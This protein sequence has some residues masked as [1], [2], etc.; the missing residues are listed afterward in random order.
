MSRRQW[1][2]SRLAISLITALALLAVMVTVSVA[3]IPGSYSYVNACYGAKTGV[4][5]VIDY[6]K[7]HCASGEKFLRWNQK[8]SPGARGLPGAQG[9][10]GP[11]S[12]LVGPTGPTGARGATGTTGASGA[13]GATGSPGPT[14]SQGIPGASGA[15]GA[16]GAPGPAGPSTLTAL[17][18]SP[19]SA[20]NSSG[21]V[22]ITT[23][24]S[25]D[26][27]VPITLSCTKTPTVTV[28]V[29]GGTMDGISLIDVT[30]G[31]NRRCQQATSCVMAFNYGD[32]FAFTASYESL[33][34]VT[35]NN[36]TFAAS[37]A[38]GEFEYLDG[39]CDINL[40]HEDDHITITIP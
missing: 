2:G 30:T 4:L 32:N 7:V 3:S 25:Q 15:P 1:S 35:C 20:D 13:P 5:R 31:T 12:G 29:T 19:C 11:A 14:G 36:S 18:G 33:F 16:P 27:S 37:S 26:S 40:I 24:T 17:E 38:A 21:V 10:P 39:G 9:L 8:G 23:G 34:H 28:T 6:P 22:A